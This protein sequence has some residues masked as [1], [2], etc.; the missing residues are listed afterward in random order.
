MIYKTIPFDLELRVT[1]QSQL[2]ESDN[3]CS[4]IAASVEQ[5]VAVKTDNGEYLAYAHAPELPIDREVQ[6]K[7]QR[8]LKSVC[9]TY[10]NKEGE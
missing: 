10:L 3:L 2:Q 1:G 6:H 5:V 7:I 4:P 8:M 9:R